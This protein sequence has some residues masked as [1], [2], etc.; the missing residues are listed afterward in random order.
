M[1]SL[2]V[3]RSVVLSGHKTSISLENEFWNAARHIAKERNQGVGQLITSIDAARRH[4][5][6]SSA[7]RL[8]VLDYYQ[9]QLEASKRSHAKFIHRAHHPH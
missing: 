6:L 3:K 7:I 8:F 5:N 2:V 9:Q 4:T 1:K